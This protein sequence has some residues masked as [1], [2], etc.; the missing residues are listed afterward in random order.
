MQ[1]LSRVIQADEAQLR[2]TLAGSI[3]LGVI[4]GRHLLKLDMLKLDTLRD[5]SPDTIISLLRPCF[6]AL[7][8]GKDSA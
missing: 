1:Q 6:H 7:T 2:A 3:V 8:A 5:A 4:V